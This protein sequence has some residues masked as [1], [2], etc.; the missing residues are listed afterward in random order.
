MVRGEQQGVSTKIKRAGTA[1]DLYASDVVD[2]LITDNQ[3]A[4]QRGSY[5]LANTGNKEQST[6][7]TKLLNDLPPILP[8]MLVGI[9]YSAS[10]Y[11]ATCDNSNITAT[12]SNEGKITVNQTIT[13][14]K[15]AVS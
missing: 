8:G 11:K 14:L 4:R 15:K 12:I 13:L 3:A 2:K 5:E 10:L 7:R 9:Q 6:I 1:A